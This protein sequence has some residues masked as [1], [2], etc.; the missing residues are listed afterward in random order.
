MRSSRAK[1]RQAVP[2]FRSNDHDQVDR[3]FLPRNRPTVIKTSRSGTFPSK[4]AS[5]PIPMGLLALQRNQSFNR[6]TPCHALEPTR[7][8]IKLSERKQGFV[9][10]EFRLLNRRL[11]HA[12]GLVIDLERNWERV[13]VLAAVGERKARRIAK[14]ARRAVH[15]LGYHGKRA[16]GS[17]ANARRQQQIGKIGRSALGRG[18]EVAVQPPQVNIAGPDVMMGWQDEMRQC[19]LRWRFCVAADRTNF[20][21][22]AVRTKFGKK[23]KLFAP[24]S[25]G[26][27]IGEIDDVALSWPFDGRVRLVNKALQV[28][29]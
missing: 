16:H 27:P 24:R 5:A 10:A 9:L 22:D 13:P 7:L 25:F 19:Q 2:R 21:C 6:R 29:R 26:A 15:D 12:N 14:A 28:L 3:L 17:R 1:S 8:L 23:L 20:A 18:G 11:E 4:N